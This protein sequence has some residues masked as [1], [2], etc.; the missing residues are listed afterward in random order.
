MR[1]PGE[2]SICSAWITAEHHAEEGATVSVSVQRAGASPS[3]PTHTVCF[4][5]A[6]HCPLSR[7]TE[8]SGAVCR[9]LSRSWAAGAGGWG[10]AGSGGAACCEATR[11]PARGDLCFQRPSPLTQEQPPPANA[12]V[13]GARTC[14]RRHRLAVACPMLTPPAEDEDSPGT[15]VPMATLLPPAPAP[16]TMGH[17]HWLS[18]SSTERHFYTC[19]IQLIKKKNPSRKGCLQISTRTGRV[20]E[21]ARGADEG[22]FPVTVPVSPGRAMPSAQTPTARGPDLRLP[23]HSTLRPPSQGTGPVRRAR[24]FGVEDGGTEAPAVENGAESVSTKGDAAT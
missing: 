14:R 20:N 11:D 2:S 8:G 3:P 24:V 6:Q 22:T 17:S 15:G 21:S 23:D 10:T 16:A 4:L 12:S 19:G 1:P 7:Q 18:Y 9:R 13:P 5:G